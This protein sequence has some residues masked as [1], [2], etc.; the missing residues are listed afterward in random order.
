MVIAL[1]PVRLDAAVKYQR[2]TIA[3]AVT[4]PDDTPVSIAGRFLGFVA[5]EEDE[6][7]FLDNAGSTILVYA[8]ARRQ[9]G[10]V[11]NTP[12]VIF[13][14]FDGENPN[15]PEINLDRVESGSGDGGG[16]GDPP[17]AVNYQRVTIAQAVT[18][19]DDTPVSIAGRFL[20]FVAGEEDEFTF[21]DNAGSTILVYAPAR[22]QAGLVFNTPLV[23]FGRFDGENPNLPEINLDRVESGSGDGGGDVSLQINSPKTNEF[24]TKRSRVVIRGI[25]RN[26]ERVRYKTRGQRLQTVRGRLPNWRAVVRLDDRPKAVVRIVAVGQSSRVIERIRITKR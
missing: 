11:F 24:S 6:F 22:R 16:G 18:L 1:A 23:I 2:V 9:A 8:P 25:A 19:P 13:G 15:L 10:L 12:L 7:T 21:L 5:G 3:Q 4:L 14:R 17:A 26:A 20:G